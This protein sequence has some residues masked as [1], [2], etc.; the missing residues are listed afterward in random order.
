MYYFYIIYSKRADIF[1]TGYS[2]E[3]QERIRKHNSNHKGFTGRFNDW[4]LVYSEKFKTK[5]EAYARE[6]QVKKW[7][8][9]D[10]I[11][12]LI[13]KSSEHPD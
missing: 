2:G 12:K 1:Y 13:T 3:L 4:K 10:R 5:S 7:K 9:R 8:N 11:V 6:R